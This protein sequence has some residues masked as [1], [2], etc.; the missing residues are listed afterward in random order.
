MDTE[1]AR[2][3]K[4]RM[5]WLFDTAQKLQADPS[6]YSELMDLLRA[7]DAMAEEENEP[8]SMAVEHPGNW[9]LSNINQFAPFPMMRLVLPKSWAGK[10]VFVHYNAT[11]SS[12]GST[13]L[14]TKLVINGEEVSG[15]RAISGDTQYHTNTVTLPVTLKSLSGGQ[16][17]VELF[18]RTPGH[19]PAQQVLSDWN[20]VVLRVTKAAEPKPAEE[21]S[22]SK[23]PSQVV[24]N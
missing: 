15:S 21:G 10:Q 18:Y 7:P 9:Q 12:H 6:L 19:F 14:C 1:E 20:C 8:T 5:R 22:A 3:K 2:A 17:V 24:I 13:H 4:A 16:V 11:I 23:K